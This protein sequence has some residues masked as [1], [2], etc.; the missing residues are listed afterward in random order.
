MARIFFSGHRHL[1]PF[2]VHI[3]RQ[4]NLI[5]EP[6][7]AKDVTYED[8]LAN[9]CAAISWLANSMEE[10]ISKGVM[11]LRPARKIWETLHSTY[12]H[13]K[14]IAR[15]CVI[16]EQL[17]TH[18]KGE[19]FV[20]EFYSSLRSLMDELKVYRHIKDVPRGISCGYF[21]SRAQSNLGFSDPW[22]GPWCKDSSF[23]LVYLFSS[24]TDLDGYACSSSSSS[25]P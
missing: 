4:V 3:G 20:Q 8:W 16:Y 17:F 1:R 25:Q 5:D 21:P 11:M 14:N 6:P 13:E 15:I 18:H 19:R 7:D 9:D 12:E 23:S 22:S 24:T 2:S 10:D